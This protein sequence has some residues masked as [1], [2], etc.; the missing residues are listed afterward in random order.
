MW[1]GS[2]ENTSEMMIRNLGAW[3]DMRLVILVSLVITHSALGQQQIEQ[4]VRVMSFNVRY[5]TAQD[6]QNHWD[7][8]KQHLAETIGNF[9]PDLLGTQE[10]LAFQRD[11]IAQRFPELQPFGAGRD[12]GQDNGEMAALFYNRHRFE[13]LA[14]GHFWLSRH[15]DVVGS[16]GWDS[17]LPRIAT[18]VKLRDKKSAVDKPILFLN[19]HFDHQGGEARAQAASL[20]RLQLAHLAKDCRIVITGDFNAAAPDSRPYSN[21]TSPQADDGL[22]RLLDS[23][24][25]TQSPLPDKHLGTFNGFKPEQI[26]GDRIDWILVSDDWQVRS[27]RID[28]MTFEGR[29]P[30]DH[31][32]VTAVIRS[33]DPVPTLRWMTYNIHHCLGL[34]NKVD[35]PGIA[36]II[37]QLDPDCVFLQEVDQLTERSGQVDQTTQLMK[38]TGMYGHFARAIDFQGG[39]YGQA[40]LSRFPVDPPRVVKLPN[41]ED[42]EQR[43]AVVS[44]VELPGYGSVQLI[45]THLDHALQKLRVEQSEQ[46]AALAASGRSVLAGDFNDT[47]DSPVLQ[48]IMSTWSQPKL[49]RAVPTIPSAGPKQQIDFILLRGFGE[50]WIYSFRTLDTQASDHLP[51]LLEM[52]SSP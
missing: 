6:G 43:V 33:R 31:F 10:T 38:L 1:T 23:Y 18:W 17:A 15:P 9:A 11:Y 5:G 36:R 24:L 22:P 32:P 42:R 28:R 41:R 4:P 48:T 30:S 13:K 40:I 50:K 35:I 52:R 19:T 49:E 44:K 14:G 34:D 51:L 26:D 37:N 21:L 25:V 2:Q 39:Q 8:R 7:N 47:F 27:A 45:G 16:K 46:F 12:D 20:I 3:L 29:V